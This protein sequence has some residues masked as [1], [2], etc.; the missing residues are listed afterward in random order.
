MCTIR[1]AT[2]DDMDA[3]MD[4]Y[5]QMIDEMVGTDF[6]ILWKHDEHPSHQ[7]LRDSVAEGHLYI[8]IAEDGNIASACVIDHTRAPGYEKVPWHVQAPLDEVGIMHS[9]ATRPSYHGRGFAS[10]LIRFALDDAR[11]R[12]WRS[13]QLDTFVDNVRS[14]GLYTKLGFINHGAF[15]V[16]YDD[17]GL[18][19]LDMFE[20]VLA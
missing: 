5:T 13:V 17:L 12:G 4:F 19:D 20:Y 8:L 10:K 15:P 2:A 18:I 7:F 9:V 11:S 1:I 16:F 6:D 14:H 3:V